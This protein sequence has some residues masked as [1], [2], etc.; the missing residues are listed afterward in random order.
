M[1]VPRSNQ[2][3]LAQQIVFR[4]FNDPYRHSWKRKAAIMI[5]YIRIHLYSQKIML[6]IVAKICE[7]KFNERINKMWSSKNG[8]VRFSPFNI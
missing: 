4:K 3:F 1:K 2:T 8:L 7:P 6:Y 5:L